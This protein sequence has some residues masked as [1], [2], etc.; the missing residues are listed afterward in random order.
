MG[1]KILY[2]IVIIAFVG[3][4]IYVLYNAIAS[5]NTTPDTDYHKLAVTSA[6][7]QVL[8]SL[9]TFLALCVSLWMAGLKGIFM[10]PKLSLKAVNDDLHCVFLGESRKGG[11]IL[12]PRLAIYAHVENGKSIAAEGCRITCNEI[13]ASVDG[14][15]FSSYTKIQT[16]SFKW[17]YST[18]EE[19][20]LSTI[21]RRVE[22]FVRIAEIVEQ[23]SLSEQ[24]SPGD[25]TGENAPSSA[26]QMQS[27]TNV[28]LSW[29]EVCLPSRPEADQQLK[30]P[31]RYKAVLLPLTV[32]SKTTSENEFFLRIIWK[33]DEVVKYKQAG[34]LSISVLTWSEAKRI[35]EGKGE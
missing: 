1:K 29:I 14:S 20:Y 4:V 33:G 25:D 27:S 32:V 17:V 23:D 22:K 35:I 24:N 3:V 18:K 5:A 21:R 28:K 34:F 8:L 11:A 7:T 12:N 19:P 6:A 26:V 9:L 10:S 2:S 30:I 31:A 15:T 13:F 16:A